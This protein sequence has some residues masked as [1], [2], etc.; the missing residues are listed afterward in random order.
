MIYNN[1]YKEFN[2]KYKLESDKKLNYYNIKINII[3]INNLIMKIIM[4]IIINYIQYYNHHH[5]YNNQVHYM[6]LDQ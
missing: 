6:D 5:I 1:K 3:I 2:Y 4:K